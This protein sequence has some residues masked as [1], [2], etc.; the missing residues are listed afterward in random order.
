MK[1]KPFHHGDTV[2]G[3]NGKQPNHTLGRTPPASGLTLN[4]ILAFLRVSVVKRI[5]Y[6]Q[7]QL[8]CE[9]WPVCVN[10]CCWV[11]SASMDQISV[12]PVRLD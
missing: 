1:I 12:W 4:L 11:P 5:C 7:L 2:N 8:G 3:Q 6:F 9:F 10:W